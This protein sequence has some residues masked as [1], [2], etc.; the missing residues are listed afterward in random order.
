[1]KKGNVLR[2][3]MVHV[4]SSK[5]IVAVIHFYYSEQVESIVGFL[6]NIPFEFDLYASASSDRSEAVQRLLKSAFPQKKIVLKKV[7]NRGFDIAPFICEFRD[8]YAD[9]DL[10]LKL[11]TKRSPHI[12]WLKEWGSYLLK[13]MAGS[14]EIVRS[15]LLMFSE[16]KT[17]GL[18]YPEIIPPLKQ[19]LMKDLWQENGAICRELGSR[20]GLSIQK[21]VP[22]DFP[23]G[24]MFWFRPKALEALFRLGLVP[25]DFPDGKR[26]RRNG[27]LAHAIERL[28]VLTA[29]KSGFSTRAVC[30]EP[31]KAVRDMSFVGR[32]R[33]RACCE[34]SRLTDFLGVN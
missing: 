27:T 2:D 34:W 18:V 20:L 6:K 15:I 13:N 7:P 30:F 24:S 17:L 28:L 5:A 14:P 9:Y 25:E 23:A 16:N 3:F 4:A 11:H 10:I 32:L 8:V 21:D 29:E 1:V 33:N 22:L 31:Y 26:I 19:E 12:P